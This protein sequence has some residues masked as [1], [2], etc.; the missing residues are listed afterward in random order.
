MPFRFFHSFDLT[1]IA[2]KHH[3]E[4][5]T[6]GMKFMI[7]RDRVTIYIIEDPPNLKEEQIAPGFEFGNKVELD[8]LEKKED[9]AVKKVVKKRTKSTTPKLHKKSKKES[10]S[11]NSFLDGVGWSLAQGVNSPP[12][13]QEEDYNIVDISNDDHTKEKMDKLDEVMAHRVINNDKKAS[14]SIIPT[15]IS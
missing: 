12:Y 8:E 15:Y 4:F 3:E 7:E 6:M 2:P 10:P 9:K 13:T 14:R 5:I 1:R 11:E